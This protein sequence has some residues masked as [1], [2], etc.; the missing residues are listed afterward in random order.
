VARHKGNNPPGSRQQAR[1]AKNPKPKS[2]ADGRWD[3][4]NASREFFWLADERPED[5]A[6]SENGAVLLPRSEQRV[7]TTPQTHGGVVAAYAHGLVFTNQSYLIVGVLALFGV[8]GVWMGSLLLGAGVEGLDRWRLE[9]ISSSFLIVWPFALIAANWLML[10]SDI[11]G[12]RYPAVLFDRAAGR[13]H[14]FVDDRITIRKPDGLY[15]RKSWLVWPLWGGGAHTILS[16]D[17]ACIRAEVVKA[18]IFT[19]VV[20][21]EEAQ[22]RIVA[23]K[24]PGGAE[25]AASI[26]IGLGTSAMVVQPTLDTWE[27]IRRFMQH[28]GPLF[29]Q[30]DGPNPRLGREPLWQAPL[31]MQTIVGPGATETWKQGSTADWLVSLFLLLCLPVLAPIGISRWVCMKL[32]SEPKWPAEILASVG[33]AELHGSELEVWRNVVPGKVVQP[34]TGL[35]G[36]QIIS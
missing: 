21:R 27:H 25:V 9:P 4:P 20:A 26:G 17:W 10:R 15:F 7:S 18:R 36:E 32:K 35:I 2:L 14:F 31:F 8:F 30:G 19:G 28:E 12:Y 24:E 29:L 13:V 22:L 33:G 5:F 16:Y 11:T 1:D 34:Q 6:G 23:T 3:N